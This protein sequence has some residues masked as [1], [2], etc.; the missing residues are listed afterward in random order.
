MTGRFGAGLA[1]QGV[2]HLVLT[3]S[4]GERLRAAVAATDALIARGWSF[5]SPLSPGV[6]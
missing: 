3:G 1:A 4:A 5:E 6:R 2:P